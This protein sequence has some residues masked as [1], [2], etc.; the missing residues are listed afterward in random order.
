MN[1]S[2]SQSRILLL[3]GKRSSPAAGQVDGIKIKRYRLARAHL[4]GRAAPAQSSASES[5]ASSRS[6]SLVIP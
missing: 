1:R 6:A 3:A 5:A 2:T 4:D